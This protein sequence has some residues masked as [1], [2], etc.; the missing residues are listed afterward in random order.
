MYCLRWDCCHLGLW[1]PDK[2][3]FSFTCDRWEAVTM[4]IAF[5]V[6]DKQSK[7]FHFVFFVLKMWSHKWEKDV[8]L[9]S[10][11]KTDQIIMRVYWA[12]RLRSFKLLQMKK[13]S[14]V[15]LG[16]FF[17]WKKIFLQFCDKKK[18]MSALTV[19][20]ILRSFFSASP[21]LSVFLF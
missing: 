2:D 12:V 1:L 19:K 11:Q 20:E 4:V 21:T 6:T 3:S 7:C 13:C 17:V 10:L 5:R 9:A 8:V 16:K 15:T 14:S 18:K